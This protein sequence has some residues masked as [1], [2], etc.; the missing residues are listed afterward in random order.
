MCTKHD[1]G[2]LAYGTLLGGF[3]SEKWLGK[4]EPQNTEVLDWSLRK[5]LRFIYAAGGWAAYQEVLTALDV[6]AKRH[7]VSIPAVAIR[8][9]LDLPAVRA[10]IVRTRLTAE[11]EKYTARNLKVFS[12]KLSEDDHAVIAKAQEGLK[13][14]PGDCGDEYRRAP[15]LTPSGSPHHPSTSE[16][17][18]RA[19][20][21]QNAVNLGERI[22]YGSG[23]PYEPIAVNPPRPT[24]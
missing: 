16:Q 14:I 20:D 13:D 11:S 22:E 18:Q 1:V 24:T 17:I 23:S 10:V 3:L 6:V 9:V 21:V 15:Y 7:S 19:K 5:Y 4:P 12:F 8:N 2:I